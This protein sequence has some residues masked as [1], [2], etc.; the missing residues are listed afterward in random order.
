ML[1]E[2]PFEVGEYKGDNEPFKMINRL[3]DVKT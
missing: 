2:K 1:R 3:L